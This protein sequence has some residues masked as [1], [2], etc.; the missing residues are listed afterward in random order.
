MRNSTPRNSATARTG[1]NHGG[2][3]RQERG[4]GAHWVKLRPLILARDK[5]LCQP[6]LA[7][8]QL[9]PATEVD[10]IVPKAKG[11]TDDADNLRSICTPCHRDKTLLD[12]GARPKRAFGS[13]GWPIDQ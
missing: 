1:W 13:D 2:K 9:T 11:G 8:G 3:S 6:C 10:H 4:Y 7:K 5:H 12:N